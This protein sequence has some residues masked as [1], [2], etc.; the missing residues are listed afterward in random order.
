MAIE[1]RTALRFSSNELVGI[2]YTISIPCH[3]PDW[4][5]MESTRYHEEKKVLSEFIENWL[6]LG[7]PMGPSWTIDLTRQWRGTPVDNGRTR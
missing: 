5:A 6:C 3:N 1:E 4:H 7:L 2:K